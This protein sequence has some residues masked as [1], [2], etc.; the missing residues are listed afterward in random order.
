MPKQ[1]KPSKPRSQ[2][3]AV[4]PKKSNGQFADR[5]RRCVV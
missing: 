3:V 1:Y 4:P 5:S 2:I